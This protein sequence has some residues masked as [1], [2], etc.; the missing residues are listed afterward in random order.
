MLKS[1]H[2]YNEVEVL[3]KVAK[4]LEADGKL[5]ESAMLKSSLLQTKLLLNIRQNQ[6]ATMT[7][8]GIQLIKP[9]FDVKKQS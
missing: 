4:Q 1:E 7:A 5:Y 8:Q 2:L 9:K 3:D 6:V